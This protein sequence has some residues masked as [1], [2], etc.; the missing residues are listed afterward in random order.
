MVLLENTWK[1]VLN[2]GRALTSRKY[3]SMW[4]L[5]CSIHNFKVTS[6]TP[7]HDLQG[8]GMARIV[9]RGGKDVCLDCNEYIENILEHIE[10]RHQDLHRW[11]LDLEMKTWQYCILHCITLDVIKRKN[12]W[13]YQFTT[14][15]MGIIQILRLVHQTHNWFVEFDIY[16]VWNSN[17]KLWTRTRPLI[18][19][20][21][22]Q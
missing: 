17:S 7:G 13:T 10:T 12:L 11:R 3:L 19:H 8:V 15:R 20:L 4:P 6:W 22:K 1:T 2:T 9:S 5:W 18:A 21:E 14:T 16:H